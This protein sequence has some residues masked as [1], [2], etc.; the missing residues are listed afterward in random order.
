VSGT[1]AP[2]RDA[3]EVSAEIDVGPAREFLREQREE[4]LRAD[5][6]NTLVRGLAHG[7]NN[8]LHV[9]GAQAQMIAQASQD[10]RVEASVRAIRASCEAIQTTF[11]GLLAST[12]ERP[13]GARV[14]T[15]PLNLA[16]C[17]EE[18]SANLSVLVPQG[19]ELRIDAE[20]DVWVRADRHV[21]STALLELM[22]NA[23]E[24]MA[25]RRGIIRVRCGLLRLS[26]RDLSD[27]RPRMNARVG[28]YG[29]VEVEDEG[30]GISAANL[31]RVFD[32]FFS[33]RFLGRGLGLATVLMQMRRMHGLVQIHST[34]DVGTRARLLFAEQGSPDA[35]Q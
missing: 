1:L 8:H 15:S 30:E 2:V 35:A 20:H 23:A 6:A 25:K 7:L 17:L 13:R 10:P 26:S 11:E 28:S 32:P 29:F 12:T 24:A 16:Q 9:V 21:V 5:M 14:A 19:C 3:H 27:L 31:P 33:T 22:K 18:W 4:Q 34:P